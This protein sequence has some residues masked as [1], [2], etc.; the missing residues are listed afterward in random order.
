MRQTGSVVSVS[1]GDSL[2]LVQHVQHVP[3]SSL[4]CA[5]VGLRGASSRYIRPATCYGNDMQMQPPP[6]SPD[7]TSQSGSTIGSR[8]SEPPTARNSAL[9]SSGD[10]PTCVKVFGVNLKRLQ[11]LMPQLKPQLHRAHTSKLSEQFGEHAPP[12]P[13]TPPAGC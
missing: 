7:F 9:M 1:P 6:P 4:S 10:P 2:S 3:S 13:P 11:P 8:G 12:S 5:S